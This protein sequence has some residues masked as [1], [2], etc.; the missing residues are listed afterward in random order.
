MVI[1]V[2]WK[3]LL[4]YVFEI[5]II[6]RFFLFLAFQRCSFTR[7]H[8]LSNS[9]PLFPLMVITC[10]HVYI[11]YIFI[12]TILFVCML[13]CYL[14][15]C[16]LY[17]CYKVTCMY[18]L[19]KYGFQYWLTLNTQSVSFPHLPLPALLSCLCFFI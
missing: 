9:W 3:L 2:S 6:I 18:V 11:K 15:I 7:P 12:N 5:L 17:A 16:Y 4:L 19:Y 14:Y 1:L 10:I 13:Q 8:S